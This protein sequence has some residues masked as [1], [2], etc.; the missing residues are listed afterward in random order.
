MA[1]SLSLALMACQLPPT[2]PTNLIDAAATEDHTGRSVKRAENEI[3]RALV[4]GDVRLLTA[5]L[6]DDLIYHHRDAW[7]EGGEF[8][9][10]DTKETLLQVAASGNYTHREILESDVQ[11]HKDIAIVRGLSSGRLK[12]EGQLIT[13]R[14]RYLRLYKLTGKHWQML[15]H[16]T[17]KLYLDDQAPLKD[18]PGP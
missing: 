17:L 11:V 12:R 3:E 15:T 5:R 13:F 8:L 4:S 9:F 18:A 1:M 6:A 16:F 2:A 14:T 10:E 7:I